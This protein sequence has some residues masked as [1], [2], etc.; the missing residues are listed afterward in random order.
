M[1][2]H[3]L[4]TLNKKKYREQHMIYSIT[5][6]EKIGSGISTWWENMEYE[7]HDD[8]KNTWWCDLVSD[9]S[10]FVEYYVIF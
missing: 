10:R 6:D 5:A 7:K 4:S 1:F 8:V 9:E 2:L 3:A